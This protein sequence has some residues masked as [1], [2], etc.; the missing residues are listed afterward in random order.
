METEG[1]KE[2]E[3]EILGERRKQRGCQMEIGKG[4]RKQDGDRE[5]FRQQDGDREGQ[6]SQR[7]GGRDGNIRREGVK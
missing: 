6:S 1:G 3:I 4:F 2:E 5:G 7:D